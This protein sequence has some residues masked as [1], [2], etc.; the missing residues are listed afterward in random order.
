MV[1]WVV[2]LMNGLRV[3]HSLEIVTWQEGQ[4]LVRYVCSIAEGEGRRLGGGGG[5]LHA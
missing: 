5:G 4:W 3:Q 1:T 2:L